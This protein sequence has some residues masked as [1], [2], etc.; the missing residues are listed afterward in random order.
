VDYPWR[1]ISLPGWD[2]T[3]NVAGKIPPWIA[4][5][6][7]AGDSQQGANDGF[8]EGSLDVTGVSA[9]RQAD[10]GFSRSSIAPR[11]VRFGRPRE[12]TS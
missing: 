1:G 3:P 4:V 11:G 2:L 5:P 6:R 7:Q 10:Q 9:A 12:T 8:S